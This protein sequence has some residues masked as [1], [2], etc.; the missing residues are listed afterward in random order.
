MR[1]SKRNYL[2]TAK[3]RQ[4]N[5]NGPA[6]FSC[7]NS[8]S[9]EVITPQQVSKLSQSGTMCDVTR[10]LGHNIRSSCSISITAATL[11]SIVVFVVQV[12]SETTSSRSHR[13]SPTDT[14]DVRLDVDW[15][16]FL[17]Q[18][19]M[20]WS[21]LWSKGGRYSIRP[22][23]EDL[24]HCGPNSAPESCCLSATGQDGNT[25]IRHNSRPVQRLT[26]HAI[27]SGGEQSGFAGAME[28]SLVGSHDCS[29]TA[30]PPGLCCLPVPGS[31]LSGCHSQDQTKW[32]F[33]EFFTVV[34][35]DNEQFQLKPKSNSSMC[36]QVSKK[37]MAYSMGACSS[38]IGS[39]AFQ[40]WRARNGT[41]SGPH[42]VAS[43]DAHATVQF[44][45][46]N[47]GALRCVEV[48]GDAREAAAIG[49]GPC[50]PTPSRSIFQ[51]FCDDKGA[52]LVPSW[53][54]VPHPPE[55]SP[56]SP[57]S[58]PGPAPSPP[59]P[60]SRVSLAAC[61]AQAATQG[62][63]LLNN[64]SV[65]HVASGWCLTGGTAVVLQPCV[66]GS[67]AQVW[68]QNGAYWID[69]THKCMGISTTFPF[70]DGTVC[71]FSQAQNFTANMSLVGTDCTN[72]DRSNM[73]G[74]FSL[75]SAEQS[76]TAR[77]AST[78]T[79][80]S[81]RSSA[82]QNLVPYTWVTSAYVGNGLVG[83]RVASEQ[84]G[85]GVLRILL[86]NVRLGAGGHRLPTG[87]F[88]ML[89]HVA[90]LP[91]RVS[92]RTHLHS[93]VLSGNLSTESS[94]GADTV[95]L[96]FTVFVN[97][98][99]S[100]PVMVADIHWQ[101]GALDASAPEFEW[102]AQTEHSM[103][104]SAGT[105]SSGHFF[106]KN[107]TLSPTNMQVFATVVDTSA[108][109]A[110]NIV[111]SAQ[112]TGRTALL[113]AHEAWWAAYWPQSF[114]SLPVT[115]VE[116][117]YFAQ[118]FRFPSSDRVTLHGLM[119]AFGPTDMFN[120]WPDDV[121]DMNEQ[122]MYWIAPGSNRPELG[123]PLKQYVRD[124]VTSVEE[125]GPNVNKRNVKETRVRS[126]GLPQGGPWFLHQYIK[127]LRYEGNVSELSTTGWQ[128]VV[129][130]A[131][132]TVGAT[133]RSTPLVMNESI[134]HIVHCDSPEYRCYPPFASRACTPSEDCNY[135]I[136]QA[137]WVV[138]TALELSL[139]FDKNLSAQGVDVRWWQQLLGSASGALAWYPYD[140]VT[141][142]R[143]DVN[144]AFECPHRHFS[145][146]LQIYDLETVTYTSKTSLD[147]A[148][149][150]DVHG[151]PPNMAR[152]THP[153]DPSFINTLIHQSIDQWYGVTCNASNWF[154]EE[155]RGF[156]QCGMA[157]MNA[158]SD[159]PDAAAGNLTNLIDCCITPNAMYGEMV[160]QDHPDEFAPVSESAY[161]GAGV[162]HTM[163]LH[164]EAMGNA[165]TPPGPKQLT[166][167]KGFPAS[168]RNAAFH[169]LRTSGGFLVSANRTDGETLFVRIAL[170][171]TSSQSRYASGARNITVHVP[172]WTSVAS[173]P[174]TI[175]VIPA[176]P[177]SWTI[178]FA[179]ADP[180]AHVILY[181]GG[182]RV[183]EFVLRPVAANTSEL[184]W[185]GYNRPIQPLH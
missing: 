42:E 111:T 31:L 80:D 130:S 44:M 170:D 118:M 183:P 8:R 89:T 24:N 144:C 19:D 54:C 10:D 77:R 37:E 71:P 38:P 126:R 87:Y 50:V 83:V 142:F 88:R 159:R 43:E 65:V 69:G 55:P 133:E 29:S 175:P 39:N 162:V 12:S 60:T 25:S 115:R 46:E 117:L 179:D 2:V 168:W 20:T 123:S 155:C 122:V 132:S 75:A 113:T 64:G 72:G 21:W 51:P 49:M 178:V 106:W 73:L 27:L 56:P 70:C 66:N 128:A 79:A 4:Q 74:A 6:T 34:L 164:S 91:V 139:E 22:I 145:H 181:E 7:M 78:G 136:S 108:T 149:T 174:D 137:R 180:S 97:A 5:Q 167:F 158:V 96:S 61:D 176:G 143:L 171:G 1:R 45:L 33:N 185:F 103:G 84:G 152:A 125:R 153:T 76:R 135:A 47:V 58:P 102:V 57:P 68:R 107:A 99:L 165:Q 157:A 163:L 112:H 86:D 110:Q 156:T 146:L 140:N 90:A 23:S 166:L 67:A 124:A 63:V 16:T 172:L 114:V 82:A 138:A 36:V 85:T 101:P 62:W 154:N 18:H 93:A 26:E 184:Q 131:I 28:I 94:T 141:G 3:Y 161:C 104:K 160:Y 15:A 100:Q 17:A 11:C 13:I 81:A 14:T 105:T 59:G 30:H 173:V 48:M 120:L 92:L 134:Y 151:T 35:T 148:A 119:G 41:S 182:R 40:L 52:S 150:S 177:S 129:A 169:Q 121:W 32:N 95:L 127:Q 53:P 9:S 109:S 147:R 116:S 98:N